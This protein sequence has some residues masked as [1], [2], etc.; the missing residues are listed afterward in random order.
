MAK[1][2]KWSNSHTDKYAWDGQRWVKVACRLRDS[3]MQCIAPRTL[4][5]GTRFS[6]NAKLTVAEEL[7]AEIVLG[8][9]QA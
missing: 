1:A 4:P 6:Y 8:Q 9:E 7:N 3:G 5:R 2:M